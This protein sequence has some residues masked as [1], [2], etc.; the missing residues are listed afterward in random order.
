MLSS[1]SISSDSTMETI[2]SGLLI[3]G[4]N[5]PLPTC[6]GHLNVTSSVLS[7]QEMLMGKNTPVACLAKRLK[8]NSKMS[9]RFMNL[10][11]SGLESN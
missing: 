11:C 1:G 8:R 10:V 5:G 9:R 7:V 3:L 6:L 2:P 4:C